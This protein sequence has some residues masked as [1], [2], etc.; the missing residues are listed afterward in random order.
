MNRHKSSGFRLLSEVP[1][2]GGAGGRG[3][4]GAVVAGLQERGCDRGL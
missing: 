4:R 3:D 2:A 1:R